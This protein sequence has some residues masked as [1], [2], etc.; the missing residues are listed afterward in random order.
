[1][2]RAKYRTSASL[3]AAEASAEVVLVRLICLSL[4]C[5]LAER[6]VKQQRPCSDVADELNARCIV[7]HT[8]PSQVNHSGTGHRW[9]R[10]WR[11]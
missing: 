5:D 2:Q 11:G 1:M 3:S 7:D 4:A 9:N 6:A 10:R 8:V